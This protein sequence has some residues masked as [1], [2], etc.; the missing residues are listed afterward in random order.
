[1]VVGTIIL[2]LCI[3]GA[4]AL[5]CFK[6]ISVKYDKTFTIDDKRIQAQVDAEELKKLEA[7]LNNQD[8]N[9][10][11]TD[12]K[13]SDTQAVGPMDSVIAEI[14]ELFGPDPNQ[15]KDESRR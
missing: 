6:G 13:D 11:N 15:V 3:L 14:H 8:K 2:G 7:K 1:M 10:P 12:N 5:I 9:Q 4:T